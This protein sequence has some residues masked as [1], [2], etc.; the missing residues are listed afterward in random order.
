MVKP[1]F[2]KSKTHQIY[3]NCFYP[4]I[5]FLNRLHSYLNLV[6]YPLFGLEITILP[7][8]QRYIYPLQLEN[9]MG[10]KEFLHM[11]NVFDLKDA[12]RT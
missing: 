9:D 10:C 12:C 8:M 1:T 3:F 7:R 2:N 4:R 11:M 5:T 6:V